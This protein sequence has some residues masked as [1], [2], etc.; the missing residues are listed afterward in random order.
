[1]NTEIIVIVFISVVSAVFIVNLI[2][3]LINTKRITEF[4]LAEIQKENSELKIEKLTKEGLLDS[5]LSKINTSHEGSTQ[6]KNNAV[7][8]SKRELEVAADLVEGL[9]AKEVAAKLNLSVYT[10]NNHVCNM[11]AKTS[12]KNKAELVAYLLKNDIL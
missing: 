1:M 4:K 2:F 11:L 3:H 5:L 8:L 9:T 6:G 12:T 7:P 10:V